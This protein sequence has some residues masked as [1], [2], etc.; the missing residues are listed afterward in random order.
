[1][2]GVLRVGTGGATLAPLNHISVY[3]G[4]ALDDLW[5]ESEKYN[6]N[7]GYVLGL[8]YSNDQRSCS[9]I[10]LGVILYSTGRTSCQTRRTFLKRV[11]KCLVI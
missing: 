6:Y 8:V 3:S 4:K 7:E 2:S 11:A 5:L 10:F 1:M 9:I